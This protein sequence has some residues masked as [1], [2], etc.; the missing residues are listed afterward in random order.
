[1]YFDVRSSCRLINLVNHL[2]LTTS[3]FRSRSSRSAILRTAACVGGR[4]RSSISRIHF[5]NEASSKLL[6]FWQFAGISARAFR[7]LIRCVRVERG[8]SYAVAAA[9]ILLYW[10][11]LKA[12]TARD[13]RS[14]NLAAKSAYFDAIMGGK[15]GLVV[16]RWL[17]GFRDWGVARSVS[18]LARCPITLKLCQAITQHEEAGLAVCVT[19]LSSHTKIQGI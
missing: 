11:F 16:I 12:S 9:R 18:W 1:V 8:T 5:F 3:S 14:S 10:A 7:P 15:L 13:M 19:P 17:Q 2:L 6:S 4:P